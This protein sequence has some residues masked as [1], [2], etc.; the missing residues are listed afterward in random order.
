MGYPSLPAELH[1]K[2]W[3]VAHSNSRGETLLLMM[4]MNSMLDL[5]M[6]SLALIQLKLEPL[7]VSVYAATDEYPADYEDA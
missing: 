7:E 6:P 2:L 5:P 1:L 4:L 3:L